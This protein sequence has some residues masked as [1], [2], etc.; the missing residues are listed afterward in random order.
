M[1]LNTVAS[2]TTFTAAGDVITYSYRVTNSGSEPIFAPIQIQSDLLGS[3][4]LE[5]RYIAPGATVLFEDVF[6]YTVTAANVTSGTVS[7][8]STAFIQIEC[9][10]ILMSQPSTLL[11]D[12]D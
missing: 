7:N 11:V 6:V 3:T 12:I 1:V 10:K 9:D 8:T 5:A 4:M 2:P